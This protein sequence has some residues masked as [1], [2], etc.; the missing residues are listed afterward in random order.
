MS[1]K[2]FRAR[3]AGGCPTCLTQFDPGTMVRPCP[4]IYGRYEHAD[5]EECRTARATAIVNTWADKAAHPL[6]EWLA[7]GLQHGS[8]DEPMAEKVRQIAAEKGLTDG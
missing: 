4:G 8:I 1:A 6:E 7:N 2:T 3:Y 5:E